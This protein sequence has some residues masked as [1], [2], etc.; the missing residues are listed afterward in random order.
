MTEVKKRGGCFLLPSPAVAN[1]FYFQKWSTLCCPDFPLVSPFR[2]A[3]GRPRQC[4]LPAKVRIIL[5]T[6]TF[7]SRKFS[8][9]APN[10]NIG[11]TINHNQLK[12]EKKKKMLR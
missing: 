10:S 8:H 6:T 3:S 1:C 4:F 11:T 2:K 5:Q 7:S 12:N 9:M